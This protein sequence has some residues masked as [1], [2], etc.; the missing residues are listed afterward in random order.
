MLV[1]NLFSIHSY[2][3]VLIHTYSVCLACK[4]ESSPRGPCSIKCQPTNLQGSCSSS[5]GEHCFWIFQYS[6]SR[7][8][9]WHHSSR[10]GS[11]CCSTFLATFLLWWLVYIVVSAY[12][13]SC[14]FWGWKEIPNMGGWA[15]IPHSTDIYESVSNA[16]S[17]TSLLL[18]ICS[19]LAYDLELP[20]GI[21]VQL[22]IVALY[23]CV[24]LARHVLC[25]LLLP[26][27]ITGFSLRNLSVFLIHWCDA[28]VKCM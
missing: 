19:K 13:A 16:R 17:S 24:A 20:S 6:A 28:L 27:C 25:D 5:T 3:Q 4:F 2:A 7:S 18:V 21:I 22:L 1:K 14:M 12:N 26:P 8:T 15:T 10:Y 11:V 9:L 23:C